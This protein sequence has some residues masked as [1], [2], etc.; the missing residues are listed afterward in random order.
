M[1]NS[2]NTMLQKN[3]ATGSVQAIHSNMLV[4]FRLI[5]KA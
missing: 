5:A 2:I 1:P 4:S 3:T